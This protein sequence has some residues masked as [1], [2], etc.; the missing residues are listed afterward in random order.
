MR[1]F[2]RSMS[3]AQAGFPFIAATRGDRRGFMGA[4]KMELALR[5]RRMT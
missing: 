5:Q 2:I 3:P 4:S 1:N